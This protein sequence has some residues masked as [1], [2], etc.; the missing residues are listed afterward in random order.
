MQKAI[1]VKYPNPGVGQPRINFLCFCFL[2]AEELMDR[3]Q[4]LF[5][6]ANLELRKKEQRHRQDGRVQCAGCARGGQTLIYRG[7]DPRKQRAMIVD[8]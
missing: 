5:V 6:Q 3:W 1:T 8:E 7:S 2:L 4:G